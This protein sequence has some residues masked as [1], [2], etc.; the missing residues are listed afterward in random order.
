MV[1]CYTIVHPPPPPQ[2]HG[3][4]CSISVHSTILQ[5]TKYLFISLLRTFNYFMYN[6]GGGGVGS[7]LIGGD[8]DVH[9]LIM[10]ALQMV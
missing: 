6:M 2:L 10:V 8:N 5:W 7:A 1:L 4:T 3:Y 9:V